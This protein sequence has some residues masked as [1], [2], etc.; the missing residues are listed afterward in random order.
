MTVW[1]SVQEVE[2]TLSMEGSDG[3]GKGNRGIEDNA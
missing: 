3:M 2:S 1:D